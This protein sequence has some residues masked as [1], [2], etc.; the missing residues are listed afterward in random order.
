MSTSP[1]GQT[2]VVG[3]RRSWSAPRERAMDYTIVVSASASDPAPLQYFA[4]Y[5]GAAIGR[6]LHV[7]GEATPCA[8]TTTCRSRPRRTARCR[9]HAASSRTRGV[10]RGRVLLPQP[11]PRTRSAKLSDELG[12]G[13]MTALPIIETLEG[14]VSA[15]IPTNVISITDGQI[16]LEPVAVLRRAS[17]PPSTSGSRSPAW[18][19][20]PRRRP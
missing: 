2:G 20:T 7:P 10:P 11:P 6:A 18:V 4:P 17:A 14:E 8:C 3:R 13:S 1:C 9:S 16:Y 15:Y 12:G 19:E 5:A